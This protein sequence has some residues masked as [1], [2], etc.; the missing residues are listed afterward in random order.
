MDTYCSTPEL[1]ALHYSKNDYEQAMRFL[2]KVQYSDV[3]YK[4]WS[5]ELLLKLYFELGELEAL[6]S[7]LHSFEQFIKRNKQIPRPQKEAYRNFLKIVA[8]L[9]RKNYQEEALR[10]EIHSKTHLRER[11]WLLKKV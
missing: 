3:S 2:N 1:A 11:K 6:H 10:T 5:K 7:L 8:R 4:L 9:M